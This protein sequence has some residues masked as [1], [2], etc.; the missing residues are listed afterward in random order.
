MR[1]P[2]CR[3]DA[4]R[5][6]RAARRRFFLEQLSLDAVNLRLVDLEKERK[7]CAESFAFILSDVE[8]RRRGREMT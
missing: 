7:N 4:A 3:R 6:R 8:C 5:S 1:R 2:P